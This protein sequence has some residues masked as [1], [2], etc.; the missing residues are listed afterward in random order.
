MLLTPPPIIEVDEDEEEEEEDCFGRRHTQTDQLI[1]NCLI[2]K[3]PQE[4]FVMGEINK[5]IRDK[6]AI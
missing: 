6:L 5:Y 1:M 2:Y 4:S 3:I